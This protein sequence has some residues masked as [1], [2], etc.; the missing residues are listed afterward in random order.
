MNRSCAYL[1]ALTL[2]SFL[3][4]SCGS[5]SSAPGTVTPPTAPTPT[6]SPTPT[7]TGPTAALT[8]QPNASF[9]TTTAFAPNPANVAVGTTVM[10]T[11]SDSTAH[12]TTSDNGVWNSGLVNPGSQFSFTFNTAGTFTYHCT[13]HPN[14][15]GTIVVQ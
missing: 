15:V 1:I 14:M 7:P 11:N 8:I 10:W 5:S 2:T 13:I 3:A 9:L 4:A 6:P 12:T